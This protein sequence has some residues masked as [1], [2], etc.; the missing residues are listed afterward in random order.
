MKYLSILTI[1]P[2]VIGLLSGCSLPGETPCKKAMRQVYLD[3]TA[4]GTEGKKPKECNGVD[5][6]TL[7]NYA[8]EILQEEWEVTRE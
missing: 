7:A 4:S 3:S 6:A 5:D 8:M 2:L 1:L